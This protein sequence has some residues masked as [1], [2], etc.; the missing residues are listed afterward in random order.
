MSESALTDR[1]VELEA[2]LK[3]EIDRNTALHEQLSAKYEGLYFSVDLDCIF[4]DGIGS[5][6]IGDIKRIQHAE[7]EQ[8]NHQLGAREILEFMKDRGCLSRV[9]NRLVLTPLGR[10]ML[11]MKG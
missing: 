1:I 11:G 2:R 5:I 6:E 8:I 7:R 3:Q 4:I 9:D 10:H